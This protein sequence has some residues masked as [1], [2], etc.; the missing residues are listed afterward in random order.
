MSH[1]GAV[2]TLKGC[3]RPEDCK[4]PVLFHGRIFTEIISVS[5]LCLSVTKLKMDS[6][7][8]KEIILKIAGKTWKTSKP[9]AGNVSGRH[10]SRALG[11]SLDFVHHRQ[12]TLGDEIKN[13]DWKLLAR[14]EKYFVKQYQAE[15]NLTAYLVL[16]TSESMSFSS[17]GA[18]K[19]DYAKRLTAVISYVF[20]MQGDAVGITNCRDFLPARGGW[21]HHKNVMDFIGASKTGGCKKISDAVNE[22]TSRINRRSLV[23]VLSDLLENRDDVVKSL[24]LSN[25][26]RNECN[27][28]HVLD[29]NEVD[30][31]YTENS[32]FVDVEGSETIDGFWELSRKYRKRMAEELEYFRSCFSNNRIGYHQTYTDIPLEDFLA[33]ILA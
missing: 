2:L 28:L 4:K 18:S 24:K 8:P 3:E 26:R 33:Q 12:Y 20:I 1:S 27:A 16:D 7:L 23:I 19:F 22:L 10:S 14:K 25:A 15:T 21:E 6:L 17:G 5:L 13:L 9:L 29:R 32:T 31:P 11:H 30:F